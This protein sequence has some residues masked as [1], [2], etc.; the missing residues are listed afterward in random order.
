MVEIALVVGKHATSPE[1]FLQYIAELQQILDDLPEMMDKVLAAREM[2]QRPVT[3]GTPT[4]HFHIDHTD[5]GNLRVS[6]IPEFPR[7]FGQEYREYS[8][9]N[10]YDPVN[11]L[12]FIHG[13][14]HLWSTR[15]EAPS[16]HDN[17][18]TFAL[19]RQLLK[20]VVGIVAAVDNQLC[21][22]FNVS[23]RWRLEEE[24]SGEIVLL[25]PQEVVER[26]AATL[27]AAVA[28]QEASERERVESPLR[29]LRAR[30]QRWDTQYGM[31][32][33]RIVSLV[34]A[35]SPCRVPFDGRVTILAT[36]F[37]MNATSATFTPGTVRSMKN[38]LATLGMQI[39]EAEITLDEARRLAQRYLGRI[40]ERPRRIVESRLPHQQPHD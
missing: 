2:A 14:D 15:S 17:D 21:Q 5:K 12:I 6:Y 37:R 13:F 39:P 35:F 24:L 27:T 33:G 7:D 32:P 19:N 23:S 3:S 30:L 9:H 31:D 36:H 38:T 4:V 11:S 18:L 22:H 10:G 28:A 1:F 20:V 34:E 8:H 26:S 25:S 16:E 40:R 29:P